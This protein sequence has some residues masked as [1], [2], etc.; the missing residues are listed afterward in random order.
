M[1]ARRRKRKQSREPKVRPARKRRPPAIVAG[2]LAAGIIVAAVFWS[3][4]SREAAAARNR[5]RA[6]PDA[7]ASAMASETPSRD[8]A[9]TSP[10]PVQTGKAAEATS[11]RATAKTADSTE[12]TSAAKSGFERLKGKWLRPD[13]GYV[14]DVKNVSDSG[15]MD[16]SYFNPRRIN[17]A[18]AEA[19]RDGETVKVFIELRDV[20]YPGSTYDLI[21]D[22]QS[23]SLRGIYYQAARQQRFEVG[24]VR[25]R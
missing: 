10:M 14:V 16:A 6:T 22:P 19:S 24:F 7:T 18:K 3:L 1:G 25:T 5:T 17:V 2:L 4:P 11:S 9:Q 8:L 13:G 21:Y 20:N 12:T 23:D 15:Q